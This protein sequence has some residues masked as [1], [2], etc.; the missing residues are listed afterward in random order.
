MSRT[1]VQLNSCST[2]V[3]GMIFRAGRSAQECFLRRPLGWKNTETG[4]DGERHALMA[5]RRAARAGDR[6]SA[7]S[8]RRRIA[9]IR[10]VRRHRQAAIGR[11]TDRW[12][13]ELERNGEGRLLL[14]R[15]DASDFRR[16]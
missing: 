15:A 9:A 5:L 10:Y 8:C 3:V 13:G 14:D 7:S 11:T 4:Y 1:M 12:R 16:K 6:D 2:E